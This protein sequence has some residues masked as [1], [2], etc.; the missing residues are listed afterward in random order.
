[1]DAYRRR[2]VAVDAGKNILNAQKV[3]ETLATL[4]LR[5]EDRFPDSSLLG[6]ARTL[7]GIAEETEHTIRW[8]EKPNRVY[9]A[10][11]IGFIIVVLAGLGFVISQLEVKNDFAVSDFVAVTEA[12]IN[13]LILIGAAV[14]F[15]ITFEVRRKRKRVITA[16]N[17]LRS[18]AHVIDAHQLTKD[19]DTV[20]GHS[21]PTKHSPKRELNRHE[22]NRYLDY[23]SELLSLTGKV[24]FLYVQRFADVFTVQIP[25]WRI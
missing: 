23:C 21:Q 3:I 2:A 9:Q 5:I 17:Q 4:C 20:G 22:L 13:E 14:A 11:G 12:A 8:I 18:I 1:M 16:L 6:V 15:I 24:A 25:F 10:L 19:P 7:Y